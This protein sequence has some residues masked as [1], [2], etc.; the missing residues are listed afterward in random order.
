MNLT[1]EQVDSEYER[2]MATERWLDMLLP[3][4]VRLKDAQRADFAD[5]IRIHREWGQETRAEILQTIG[6]PVMKGQRPTIT[7][8][9]Y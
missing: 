6:K 8:D 3:N 4:G 2:A 5:A 9:P 7:S 1:R